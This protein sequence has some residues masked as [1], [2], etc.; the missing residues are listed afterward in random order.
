M[1]GVRGCRAGAAV[2]RPELDDLTGDQE[3]ALDA[4]AKWHAN[5]GWPPLT[6]GG[7]AGTGKTTLISLLPGVL[8]Q[9]RIAYAA[10]TGKAVSVLAGKLADAGQ[11]GQVTTLHRLLYQ[12]AG[13]VLCALSG[14]VLAAGMT[15]CYVHAGLPEGE[16]CPPRNAVSFT[17]KP[18]PLAGLDL[19]VADEASMIPGQLWG[20]LAGHGV[21]VLAV[22]DHGQLPPVQSS[23]NLMARPD[24]LLEEIHRQHAASPIHAV[25][26]WARGRG[27]IPQGA[28]GPGV[29]KIRPGDLGRPGMGLHPAEADL[30]ICAT[31][32]TRVWHNNAMRDWHG[33]SGP[34][35]AG[36]RVICLRNNRDQGLF[37]GQLGTVLDVSGPVMA[38]GEAAWRMTIA[39]EDLDLPWSGPVAASPFGQ[40]KP[41]LPRD[42]DLAVFDFGYAITAHKSQ[43]S[44]APRVLV[45]EEG[46]PP[47]GGD[48]FRARWLYT[49]VTRAERELTVAG[50]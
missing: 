50:W 22:G 32:A 1:P 25:A 20:D 35:C 29:I 43:G 12:P 23:F 48:D 49:A 7:L 31:N 9:A 24:L 14:E 44:E 46:W 45:I 39:V 41:D 5:G 2:S 42:R 3:A 11:D 13:Q 6:L 38:G 4:I 16:P 21:P 28:Y 36:D 37:N 34:P 8:P 10:Y 15:R 17:P 19:V 18:D 40:R 33:R 47:P 27:H 30:I 26:Q